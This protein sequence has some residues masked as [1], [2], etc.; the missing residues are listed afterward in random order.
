M[1]KTHRFC[2][3]GMEQT[4]RWI[5]ESLNAPYTF[6]GGGHNNYMSRSDL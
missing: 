5:T 1:P 2:P 4:D 3:T 6:G